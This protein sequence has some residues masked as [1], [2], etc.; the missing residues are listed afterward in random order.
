MQHSML[1]TFMAFLACSLPVHAS[2]CDNSIE[3]VVTGE[4]EYTADDAYEFG[5]KIKKIV[6]KKDSS[7]LFALFD[8]YLSDGPRKRIA[9]KRSFD[10]IFGEE[11]R[12]AVL[13]GEPSCE[14]VGWRGFMLGSGEIWYEHTYD[15]WKIIR[16]IGAKDLESI[17]Y[18]TKWVFGKKII[19]PRCFAW[20]WMSND[21]FELLA[22]SNGI[23]D[24]D[25]FTSSPGQFV[26]AQVKNYSPIK[27]SWCDDCGDVFLVGS[28]DSCSPNS[29]EYDD[30][31]DGVSIKLANGLESSYEVISDVPLAVCNKLAPNISASCSKSALILVG[32]TTGGSMPWSGAYGVYG[33]F[34][35]P[36]IGYSVVPLRFFASENEA[37]N[38]LEDIEASQASE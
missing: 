24:I 10:E 31:R 18:D 19:H 15:G 22:E 33:F 35:L 9:L 3:F 37:R 27:P 20:P 32:E 29:F 34:D 12:N 25:T 2:K 6:A 23:D 26:G 1:L 14:P 8:G 16:I 21:N 5:Q 13:A 4:G 7:A 17:P 36:D 30:S 11:W 38:E 28:L